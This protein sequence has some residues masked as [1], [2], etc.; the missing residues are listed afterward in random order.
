MAKHMDYTTQAFG[1]KD[2]LFLVFICM[3]EEDN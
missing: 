3:Q 2:R 1:D